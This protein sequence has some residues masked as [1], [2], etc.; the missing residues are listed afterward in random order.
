MWMKLLKL[1]VKYQLIVQTP[2]FTNYYLYDSD[3]KFT[4]NYVNHALCKGYGVAM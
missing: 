4:D 1:S 2:W 3:Q